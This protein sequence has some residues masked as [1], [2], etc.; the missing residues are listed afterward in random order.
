MIYQQSQCQ[1]FGLHLVQP[2]V[3][4]LK[5]T[6]GQLAHDALSRN[7]LELDAGGLVGQVTEVGVETR[8]RLD[9]LLGLEL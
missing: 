1:S 7:D 4:D 8:G 9:A 6:G 2:T 5:T 3:V